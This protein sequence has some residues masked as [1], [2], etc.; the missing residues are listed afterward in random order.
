MN[1]S[2]SS[3][4]INITHTELTPLDNTDLRCLCGRLI[5]KQT[6]KGIEI[7]CPRCKRTWT[8]SKKSLFSSECE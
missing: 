4:S 7:R 1:Y 2:P 3:Q 6:P 8:F 5:A